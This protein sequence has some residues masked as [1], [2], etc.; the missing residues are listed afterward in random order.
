MLQ[1]VQ[2]PPHFLVYNVQPPPHLLV[3]TQAGIPATVLKKSGQ[4]ITFSRK[5]AML[6]HIMLGK[7]VQ[8]RHISETNYLARD[9]WIFP[10][11]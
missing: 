9:C 5:N 1:N 3:Y 8:K 10:F 2:P 7:T 4:Q 11:A 6:G